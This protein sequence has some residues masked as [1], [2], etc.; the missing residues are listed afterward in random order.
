MPE[1]KR[2]LPR[3]P[4]VSPTGEPGVIPE[5]KPKPKPKKVKEELQEQKDRR[6]AREKKKEAIKLMKEEKRDAQKQLKAIYESQTEQI[7]ACPKRT[8]FK[9]GK[10][11]TTKK[12]ARG[13]YKKKSTISRY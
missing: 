1:T 11:Y 8:V 3:R 4:K 10:N 6:I 9:V 5:D 12:S 13:P 2:L 7:K